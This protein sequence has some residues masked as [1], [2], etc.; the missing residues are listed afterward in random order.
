MA[1]TPNW[2]RNG[3]ELG[4]ERALLDLRNNTITPVEKLW[5]PD[6]APPEYA[7]ALRQSYQSTIAGAPASLEI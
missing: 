4:R 6:R 2:T 5:I 1:T 3:R 7:D